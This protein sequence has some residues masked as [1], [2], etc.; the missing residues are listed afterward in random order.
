MGTNIYIRKLP[1]AEQKRE[2]KALIAQQYEQ[3]IRSI[4]ND[5][6]LL[7]TGR[8]DCLFDDETA[9]LRNEMYKEVHIGKCSWGWQFLFAPNPEY[10]NETK[11]S[12]LRFIHRKTWQLVDEYGKKLDPDKFWDEYVTSHENGW[13]GAGYD[14]YEREKGNINHLPCASYEHVT[15]E[16]LR[17]AHD[18]DFA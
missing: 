15:S 8:M 12:I 14:K 2:L 11:E 10:Y 9:S 5:D 4:E 3:L 13:D 1:T 16:G 7:H 17:F 6:E 18:A